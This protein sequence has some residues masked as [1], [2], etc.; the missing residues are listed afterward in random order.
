MH[1]QDAYCAA[2]ALGLGL[3][4]C[5]RCNNVAALDWLLQVTHRAVAVV[6]CRCG[7]RPLQGGLPCLGRVLDG[8]CAV[9]EGWP[10]G[11]GDE[12]GLG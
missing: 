11:R 3:L 7:P 6:R 9:H 5:C 10:G 12:E 2:G 1:A 8:P 4:A